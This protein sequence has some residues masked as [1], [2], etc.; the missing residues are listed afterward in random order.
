MSSKY[1]SDKLSFSSYSKVNAFFEI[2]I[3]RFFV[4]R[5]PYTETLNNLFTYVYVT[6]FTLQCNAM[7]SK[8]ADVFSERKLTQFIK[9]V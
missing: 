1:A 2:A 4:K 3:F 9:V 7:T 5:D 6:E 8:M